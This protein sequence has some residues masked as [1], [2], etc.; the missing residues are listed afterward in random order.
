MAQRGGAR[1]ERS[2]RSRAFYFEGMLRRAKGT[3][4][5]PGQAGNGPCACRL[6]GL[7]PVPCCQWLT[8]SSGRR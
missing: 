3:R 5:A 7:P 6:A 8:G 4:P 1:R 2:T